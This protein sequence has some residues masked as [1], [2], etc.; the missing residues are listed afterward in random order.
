MLPHEPPSPAGGAPTP[1][2]D[3]PPPGLAEVGRYRSEREAAEHGLVVLAMRLGYWIEPLPDGYSLRVAIASAHEVR[4]QLALFDIENVNWPPRLRPL[5]PMRFAWAGPLAWAVMV[6]ATY[7][8]QV[9]WPG[10]LEGWGALRTDALFGGGELWRPLTALFLHGDVAHLVANLGAGFFLFGLVLGGLGPRRGGL[11][12]AASSIVGNVAA[13]AL[14]P[15]HGY[16]SLG[17]STAVFAALGMLTGASVREVW[18]HGGTRSWRAMALPF[19]AGAVLL[20]LHGSGGLQTDVVAHVTG[21]AAGLIPGALLAPSAT[22][23][24]G[25]VRRCLNP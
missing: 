7:R 16:A 6:I 2:P 10:W 13:A 14:H 11:A 4:A 19:F 25:A 12:L 9:R 20:A 1:A 3:A 23:R 15:W 5:A 21:F 24:T 17:A 18:R 22:P 8:L